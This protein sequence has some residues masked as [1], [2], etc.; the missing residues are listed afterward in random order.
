MLDKRFLSYILSKWSVSRQKAIW[1]QSQRS[2]QLDG[3]TSSILLFPV[4]QHQR[5]EMK[6][7]QEE[8]RTHL[9]KK[10]KKKLYKSHSS[11]ELSCVTSPPLAEPALS[12]LCSVLPVGSTGRNKGG[13]FL[14]K[15][16]LLLIYVDKRLAR[17]PLN[18]SKSILYLQRRWVMACS[19]TQ[20]HV[21]HTRT[22]PK[23]P[24]SSNC[25]EAL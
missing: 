2:L 4:P 14:C 11:L 7:A 22:S 8:W 15:D 19:G 13:E 23:G 24:P 16:P 17:V 5:R 12:P 6:E 21:W 1:S 9:F 20:Y 3:T 10:K 18:L 25:V